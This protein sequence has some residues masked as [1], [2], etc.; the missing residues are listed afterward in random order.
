MTRRKVRQITAKR[1]AFLEAARVL[2]EHIT[3]EGKVR[4]YIGN[5]AESLLPISES[6]KKSGWL[7]GPWAVCSALYFMSEPS[8]LRDLDK[9]HEECVG[10]ELF[11]VA[12]FLG[13]LSVLNKDCASHAGGGAE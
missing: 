3:E 13:R 4:S 11:L 2:Q 10:G 8:D 7:A 5:V 12:Y 6:V 1:K 9:C